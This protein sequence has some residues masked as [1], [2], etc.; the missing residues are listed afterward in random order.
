MLAAL[1]ELSQAHDW[2]D[3]LVQ[4]IVEGVVIFDSEGR[5]TFL[6]EKAA[7]LAGVP[8]AEGIGRLVDDLLP[9]TNESGSRVSVQQLA[10]GSKLRVNLVKVVERAPRPTRRPGQPIP[11]RLGVAPTPIEVTAVVEITVL[12]LAAPAGK[13]PPLATHGMGD[14]LLL[15]APSQE[16]ELQTA[17]VLRDMSQEESLRH[18]RSYFLANITHEFRTPLSTW[19]ASMELLLNETDLTAP[20]MRELLKPLHL[21][22]LTLQTLIENLL[23]SS[24]IEA[25]RFVLRKQQVDLDQRIDDAVRI[26]QPLFERRNQTFIRREPA[27]LPPLV[28]DAARLT[29]VLVNLLSNA[30]NYSPPGSM[31]T[32][33]IERRGDRLRVAVADQGPGIPPAEREHLFQRFVRLNADKPEQYGIGLG[34]YVVKTTIEAH[35]GS[36]GVD[37]HSGG[38]SVFWFELPAAQEEAVETHST[39][40]RVA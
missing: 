36:V 18:L 20:E 32:L 27:Y 17:L 29:Q 25:G 38:G 4:S 10:V 15:D 31:I 21:S 5:V 28:G 3:N 34:L 37:E 13:T 22:L 8:V 39:P 11:R 35:G 6:N 33:E 26:V 24:A 14:D 1:D 40:E 16:P 30:S 23:E 12:R 9:A 2:L 7:E 19:N